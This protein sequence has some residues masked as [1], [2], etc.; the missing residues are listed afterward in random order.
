MPDNH[1]STVFS[2]IKNFRSVVGAFKNETFK[3]YRKILL[4]FEHFALER[5]FY[6]A[7]FSQELVFE[8]YAYLRLKGHTQCKS[9]YYIDKLGNLYSAVSKKKKSPDL[10]FF[11]NIRK[12]I[13]ETDPNEKSPLPVTF[14]NVE[15]LFNILKD[16]NRHPVFSSLGFDL[17]IYSLSNGALSLKELVDLKKES[18]QEAVGPSR[19]IAEKYYAPKRK[20]IFPLSQSTATKKQSREMADA[21][22]RKALAYIGI[23]PGDTDALLRCLW[24]CIA[25]RIGVSPSAAAEAFPL[26]PESYPFLSLNSSFCILN[27]ESL[28]PL[29]VGGSAFCILN[30]KVAETLCIEVKH[31]Y[32]MR[33]RPYVKY[34]QLIAGL[35]AL[36]SKELL[37]ELF[38]PR[39][40]IARRAGKK[41][42]WKE[43]PVI[44]DIVFFKT[45]PDNIYPLFRHIW[46]I[47]WCYRDISGKGYAAIPD[48]AMAQFQEAIGYFT[49]DFEIAPAGELP[50]KPGDKVTVIEG[51]FKDHLAV[52][53]DSPSST[54]YRIRLLD[55]HGRWDISLDARLLRPSPG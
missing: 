41:I 36:E 15:T 8:W 35:A 31:W 1:P 52:I 19:S 25:V 2:S 10:A 6:D 50:L 37:P 9:F 53:L 18:L 46:E 4:S 5:Y 7:P 16:K 55:T 26:L 11:K 3:S 17:L 48:S 29:G 21:E 20:Y 45:K 30:S 44:N 14:K 27:S 32:A 33:L 39:E 28:S 49:P 12:K 42:V 40:E 13:K 23:S 38:Y 51:N 22:I 43:K 54:V 24:I 47:A 34:D